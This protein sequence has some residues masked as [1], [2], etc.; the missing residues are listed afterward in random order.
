LVPRL[1]SM[2]GHRPLRDL[3][4][5]RLSLTS[6]SARSPRHSEAPSTVRACW[7]P[8][9]P[10]PE[11][12]VGRSASAGSIQSV[13]F[14]RLESLMLKAQAGQDQLTRELAAIQGLS[15]SLREQVYRSEDKTCRSV[16]LSARSQSTALGGSDTARSQAHRSPR[17]GSASGTCSPRL[18]ASG[19]DVSSQGSCWQADDSSCAGSRTSRQRQRSTAHPGGFVTGH[20]ALEA[21][22]AEAKRCQMALDH[23]RFLLEGLQSKVQTGCNMHQVGFG[24]SSK[25]LGHSGS[26][27]G[28]VLVQHEL[29]HELVSS[30]GRATPTKP[31]RATPTKSRPCTAGGN[32]R[33]MLD[34]PSTNWANLLQK[35]V[36]ENRA[37]C[38]EACGLTARAMRCMSAGHGGA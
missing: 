30:A 8:T 24:T 37:L 26:R 14:S 21:L 23:T 36:E 6:A 19:C 31:G 9:P 11:S 34:S 20:E 15:A 10:G 12:G 38:R 18:Q 32:T 33:A 22:T 7:A 27:A 16:C 13:G 35:R 2:P 1:S 4:S 28:V 3:S 25:R 29:R 5:P 17:S